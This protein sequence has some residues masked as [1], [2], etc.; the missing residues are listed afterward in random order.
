MYRKDAIN[1]DMNLIM[2]HRAEVREQT[3]YKVGKEI[4]LTLSNIA[5]LARN[6]PRLLRNVKRLKNEL[7]ELGIKCHFFEEELKEVEDAETN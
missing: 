5:A 3:L 2:M 6:N 7:N 1:M 4:D